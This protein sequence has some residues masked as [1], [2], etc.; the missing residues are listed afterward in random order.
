MAD[1]VDSARIMN[2]LRSVPE[3]HLLLI[4]LAN[5]LPGKRGKLEFE[6]FVDRQAELNLAIA[7]ARAYGDATDSAVNALKTLK[8]RT[9]ESI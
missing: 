5:E 2:A 8:A 3:K 7:E 9:G 6:K 4:D 1:Q